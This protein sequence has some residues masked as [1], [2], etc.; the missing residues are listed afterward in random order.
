MTFPLPLAQIQNNFTET[1]RIPGGIAQSVTCLAADA[2]LTSD[3]GVT[4]LILAR[5]NTFVEID[6]EIISKVILL[7][8]AESL[9][10]V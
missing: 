2:I 4:S 3:P 8:S 6:H 9:K 5:S 1:L 7:L 10:K